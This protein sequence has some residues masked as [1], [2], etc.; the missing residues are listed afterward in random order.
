MSELDE[1]E[2]EA[3]LDLA[4]FPEGEL[5]PASALKM[6]WSK[7]TEDRL[8]SDDLVSC[9]VDNC[10]ATVDDN[11][12]LRL[13]NLQSAYVRAAAGNSA[14]RHLRLLS[15]YKQECHGDWIQGPGFSDGDQ[16]YFRRLPY[17][18][19]RAGGRYHDELLQLLWNPDWLER[20]AS[21]TSISQV[22]A[23]LERFGDDGPETRR[24]CRALELSSHIVAEAPQQLRP[25]LVGRLW[26]PSD[27]YPGMG[28]KPAAS[29]AN[30]LSHLMEKLRATARGRL[31]LC[32][33]TSSLF[34][35]D[36]PLVRTL[37]RHNH[38]VRAVAV[39]RNGKRAISG[40]EEGVIKLWELET[41]ESRIIGAHNGVIRAVTLDCSEKYAVS[42]SED[43]AL[44]VWGL[45]TGNLIYTLSGHTQ[46]VTCVAVHG[47]QILSGSYDKSI[48]IWDIN[49]G[50]LIQ[51]LQYSS[52]I[53]ALVV[54]DSTEVVS[55]SDYWLTG[56][57]PIPA[58]V[59][60]YPLLHLQSTHWRTTVTTSAS[61][62]RSAM[63]ISM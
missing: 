62:S 2:Q 57:S 1:A 48:R 15:A 37:L 35:P 24:L 18:L 41:G 47:Q 53:E 27:P 49:S 52:R 13:H 44:K 50:Q 26:R 39:T 31:W 17:H 34:P 55:A 3:Y 42:G 8:E 54:P 29:A 40:C 12:G 11:D 58:S 59:G 63:G 6:L 22:V 23:D 14:D 5:I 10:L 30:P 51:K 20:K 61:L 21:L 9:F 36:G 33:E 38:P 56:W 25:Q 43:G 60:G 19:N 32:P 45:D 4:V 16:Y 28:G 46:M 7:Y